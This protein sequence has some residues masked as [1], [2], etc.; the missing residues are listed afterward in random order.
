MRQGRVYLNGIY[1]GMLS[2]VPGKG[3]S[4]VYDDVYYSNPQFPSISLTL[5]KKQKLFTSPVLFPFFSNMLSEGYNRR[6]QAVLHHLD[7][8][9]DFGFLL[10]TAYCDTPGAV[11]VKKN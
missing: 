3:Y 9:D 4:F 7:P 6:L 2:E 10:A 1:A 8:E 11:T 5:P